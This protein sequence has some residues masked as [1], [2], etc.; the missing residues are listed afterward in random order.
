MAAAFFTEAVAWQKA[1][2]YVVHHET[3]RKRFLYSPW[4]ARNF[5]PRSVLSFFGSIV[6]LFL[7]INHKI[8]LAKNPFDS[9]FLKC[10]FELFDV[11][12]LTSSN[13]HAPYCGL[14]PFLQALRIAI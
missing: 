13:L 10:S 8:I 12:K 1:K 3:H 9:S 2:G 5:V 14:Q 4:V 11:Q 7:W 6:K